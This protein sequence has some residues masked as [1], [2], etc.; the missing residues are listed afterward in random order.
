M[1]APLEEELEELAIGGTLVWYASICPRQVWLMVRQINPDEDDPNL[2]YG[3]FL[4]ETA[5]QR[6]RRNMELGGSK[7]DVVTVRNDTLVI[8]EVKKSSRA[9]ES[10]RLQLAHYLLLLEEDGIEAVG[11]LRF[12]EER[13]KE[14][15]VLTDQ[16]RA[17]VRAQRELVRKVAA[18]PQ[19]PP[20]KRVRWCS[21]CAYAELCWG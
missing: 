1:K 8:A 17:A 18:Q 4:H 7:F 13:R 9:L 5:Y 14:R 20:P 16:L 19:P 6:E 10:A 11:E 2:E 15:V 21:K 12:P 3:R